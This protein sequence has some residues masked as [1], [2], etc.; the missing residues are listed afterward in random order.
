MINVV[1]AKLV[2]PFFFFNKQLV[3]Q[4]ETLI[5]VKAMWPTCFKRNRRKFSQKVLKRHIDGL[6][7]DQYKTVLLLLLLLLLLLQGIVISYRR[8]K[9]QYFRG[10]SILE[11]REAL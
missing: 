2:Q 11:N 3:Q 6:V 10:K 4:D 5:I 9:F 7:I 8:V 1:N